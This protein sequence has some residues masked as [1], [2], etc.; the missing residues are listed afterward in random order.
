VEDKGGGYRVLVGRLMERD[1]FEDL[2]VDG[3]TIGK[4][5]FKK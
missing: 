5:I 2:G 4:W 3:R 1:H